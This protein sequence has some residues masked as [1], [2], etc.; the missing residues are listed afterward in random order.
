M[1]DKERILMEIVQRW[2]IAIPIRTSL[3]EKED[4]LVK[5]NF[6][7]DKEY[8]KG[9]LVVATSTFTINDWVVGFV[10]SVEKDHI[11]IRE[12]GTKRLCKYYNE[13]F[14]IINKEQFGTVNLLEGTQY[15]TYQKVR[16]A[17]QYSINKL[18]DCRFDGN[19]CT[20]ET[21]KIFQ[22]E[23]LYSFSFKYNSKTP[24]KEIVA[25]ILEKEERQ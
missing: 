4:W 6:W 10:H 22:D 9:D 25:I 16:K 19:I 5:S 14:S 12:I 3:R 11:V 23:L 20:V 8:K 18:R 2:A 13:A 17:M 1:T 7:G 15:K 24:I 21:R